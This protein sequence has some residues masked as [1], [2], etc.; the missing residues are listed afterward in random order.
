MSNHERLQNL[1]VAILATDG[2]E[3]VELTEPKRALEQAGA[4]IT[5][6]AP[7]LGKVQAFHHHEKGSKIKVDLDLDHAN[8]GDY[9]ALLLPGGALNADALR[10]DPKAQQFVQEIDSRGKPMAVICHAPW[11]LVSAGVAKGRSLT[12]WG[13]LEDDITNAGGRW[14]DQ[15]VLVDQNLVTSRGPD[16][17]AQFNEAMIKLFSGGPTRPP[18]PTS[19]PDIDRPRPTGVPGAE[20]ESVS[21]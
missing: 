14:S 4:R 18:L 8:A 9:G 3:E 10:V 21:G 2:V 19:P 11:I 12:S 1:Q 16:D 15:A 17:L 13:S 5:I 6:I 20:R 7:K